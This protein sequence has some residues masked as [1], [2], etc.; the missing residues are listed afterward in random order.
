MKKKTVYKHF[1]FLKVAAQSSRGEC[2]EQCKAR[3][4]EL[5]NELADCKATQ[6]WTDERCATLEHEKSV[7]AE[8]LREKDYLRTALSVVQEQNTHLEKSLSDEN[9]LKLDLFS[10]LGE[11]K[12]EL[13][14]RE[15]MSKRF[16]LK[17]Y[18]FLFIKNRVIY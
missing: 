3:R 7:I 10:A 5:E 1:I 16:L 17:I 14:I 13:E 4:R 9:R 11:T 12:R 2:T 8:Q 18:F 6:R 15:S